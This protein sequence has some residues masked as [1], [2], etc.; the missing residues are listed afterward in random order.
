M[1]P[2][3]RIEMIQIDIDI[4]QI[5]LSY[6][7]LGVVGDPKLALIEIIQQLSTKGITKFKNEGQIIKER[8]KNIEE[9]REDHKNYRKED[10]ENW[11]DKDPIK[12]QRV[13]KAISDNFTKND[14]LE[15]LLE[16]FW[17]PLYLRI[18]LQDQKR[19]YSL[20]MGD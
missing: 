13:L 15:R 16:L 19:F 2:D 11:M 20:E 14:Y 7:P 17:H 4:A 3:Q 8:R 10:N 6:N 5:G 12:P 9:L 18:I 1:F